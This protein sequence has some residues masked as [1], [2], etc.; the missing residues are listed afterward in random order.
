MAPGGISPLH[1]AIH[2]DSRPEGPEIDSPP[3]WIRLSHG[4]RRGRGE[5]GVPVLRA[6]GGSIVSGGA[7]RRSRRYDAVPA[8]RARRL[9]SDF[10]LSPTVC[11]TLESGPYCATTWALAPSKALCSALATAEVLSRAAA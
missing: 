11:T 2:A 10:F 9:R 6:L 7:P 1:T 3:A 5:W 8:R 4:E